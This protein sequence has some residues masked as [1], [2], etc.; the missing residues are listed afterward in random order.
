LRPDGS[1]SALKQIQD[2]A[3]LHFFLDYDGTLAEFAKTPD[4]IYPDPGLIQLLERLNNISRFK[5]A[6]IS[7]RRLS[8]IRTLI[9]VPGILLAGTYGIELLEP[10]GRQI[11][12]LD[13]EMVRPTLDRIK[14]L[15]LELLRPHRDFYLEDKGWSLAIHAKF[16]DQ[17][18][19]DKTISQA[20]RIVDQADLPADVFRVLGGHKF[21][22]I[23][24][25]L[26]NKGV[27][28]QYLIS[29]SPLGEALPCYI[30]DDDKDEEAFEVIIQNSGVAIKVC[31]Q[32]CD[33]KA[34]LCID[35]PQA[36]R[37]FLA[38]LL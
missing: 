22:E 28:V 18:T 25:R 9:P 6:I 13:Y 2:A 24:P 7:G 37:Q 17:S 15:W 38:S 4:E 33:T 20:R 3:K 32:P 1:D 31:S 10:S 12:R 16:V 8:H 11:D 19:A 21:L 29:R 35:S 26:A 14:P 36:V 5:V 23:A 30:G 34:Q 27:T